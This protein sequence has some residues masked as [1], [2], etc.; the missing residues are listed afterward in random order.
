MLDML[1][2]LDVSNRKEGAVPKLGDRAAEI[3]AEAE[4]GGP[5]LAKAVEAALEP[6]FLRQVREARQFWACISDSGHR[7]NTTNFRQIIQWL[8]VPKEP[9]GN[10]QHQTFKGASLTIL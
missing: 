1:D 5:V 10:S 9:R 8:K 4:Q 2:M 7:R 3:V 6:L